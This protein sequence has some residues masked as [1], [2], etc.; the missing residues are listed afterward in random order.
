LVWSGKNLGLAGGI[1]LALQEH[2]IPYRIDTGE[3]GTA[4]VLSHPENEVR[5]REIVREIVEG[6]RPG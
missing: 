4:K 2:E 5:A 3:L 1:G 6:A